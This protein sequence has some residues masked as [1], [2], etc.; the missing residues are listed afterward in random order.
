MKT[1]STWLGWIACGLFASSFGCAPA[2]DDA[3]GASEPPVESITESGLLAKVELS[4]THIVEFRELL[5]GELTVQEQLHA[6][7]DQGP[8]ANGFD[9]SKQSVAAF[10]RELAGASAKADQLAALQQFETRA[11]PFTALAADELE[12]SAP[13]TT[14]SFS[15]G[16]EPPGW[17]FPGEFSWFSNNFCRINTASDRCFINLESFNEVLVA[18]G[19]RGVLFNQ[20]F[21]LRAQMRINFDPCFNKPSFPPTFCS[22]PFKGLQKLDLAPRTVISSSTWTNKNRYQVA[23]SGRHIG[24][25]VDWM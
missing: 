3:S 25:F 4:E 8:V 13:E 17:D 18:K 7:R 6:D 9:P 22:D 21:T 2:A 12:P 15:K 24:V 14:R 16:A 23:A 11:L 1:R 20:D 5:P 10:Y 19:V